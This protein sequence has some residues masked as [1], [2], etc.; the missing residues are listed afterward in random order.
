MEVPD[1]VKESYE[2]HTLEYKSTRRQTNYNSYYL[3]GISQKDSEYL[4]FKKN[5][6]QKFNFGIVM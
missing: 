1:E 2:L 6:P 5:E 4:E 3:K